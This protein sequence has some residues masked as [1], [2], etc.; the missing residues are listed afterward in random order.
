MRYLAFP[1][2]KVIKEAFKLSIQNRLQ[3]GVKQKLG[4]VQR[5]DF[6]DIRSN[7]INDIESLHLSQN[8]QPRSALSRKTP[9]SSAAVAPALPNFF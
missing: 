9:N 1:R 7:I 6:T 3:L 2:L 5:D 8:Q 4:L